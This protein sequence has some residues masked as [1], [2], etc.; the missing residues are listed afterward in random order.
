MNYLRDER[1]VD[2]SI[3]YKPLAKLLDVL[4]EEGA[5]RGDLR[6]S[7]IMRRERE[8]EEEVMEGRRVEST[9]F[10]MAGRSAW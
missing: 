9:I 2:I 10:D 3:E 1:A 6:P 8:F 5:V 7:H 4:Q